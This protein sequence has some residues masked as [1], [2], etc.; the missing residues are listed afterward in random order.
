MFCKSYLKFLS[1]ALQLTTG[2]CIRCGIRIP[3]PCNRSSSFDKD[4][5]LEPMFGEVG[6]A[7]TNAAK[8]LMPIATTSSRTLLTVHV[9]GSFISSL[10]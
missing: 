5:Y 6:Q 9:G 8:L 10:M 2:L 3:T 1:V 7:R 4:K